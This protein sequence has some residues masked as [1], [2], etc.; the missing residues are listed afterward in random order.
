MLN[1]RLIGSYISTLRKEKD[2]TQVELADRLNVSHQAVS[3]WERGDSL[4]DI[5]TLVELG[6]VFEKTIDSILSGGKNDTAPRNVGTIVHELAE[7]HPEKVAALMNDGHAEVEGFVDLAPLLKTSTMRKVTELVDENKFTID[8][9][10]HLAP[11]LEQDGLTKLIS[12][13]NLSEL[14][15]EDIIPLAPFLR[16]DALKNITVNIEETPELRHIIN[17]APFVGDDIN[18]MVQKADLS[19]ANWHDIQSLAPFVN[20]NTLMQ[21]I[22]QT[23]NEPLSLE[24][25]VSV[26][27]FLGEHMDR[28]LVQAK[29]ESLSLQQLPV[30]APFI[31]REALAN[32]IDKL[33]DKEL[34]SAK[35]ISIMPFIDK[36]KLDTLLENKEIT[37]LTPALLA[38]MAPF[39]KKETLTR[40]MSR[41]IG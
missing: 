21:L 16:K 3:K 2:L 10:V 35:L 5:G 31:G 7:N 6:K 18:L 23:S 36:E 39:V 41:L 9:L 37:N 14:T 40:L 32:L 34:D 24:Q 26:A 8:N 30:L 4:P 25:I 19:E 33:P 22:D 17:L 27:P 29:I 15:W 13:I 1:A 28:L 38:D 12:S 11:F 20:S